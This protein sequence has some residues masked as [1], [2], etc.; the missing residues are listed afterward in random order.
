[1]K[2]LDS[3][4][5]TLSGVKHES[6]DG[7]EMSTNDISLE[8]M[9]TPAPHNKIVSR[10]DKWKNLQNYFRFPPL[11]LFCIFTISLKILLLLSKPC[12]YPSCSLLVLWVCPWYQLTHKEVLD[13]EVTS[14]SID[15]LYLCPS[16]WNFINT[17]YHVVS[18]IEYMSP[19]QI[20]QH[21][22]SKLHGKNITGMLA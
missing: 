3:G 20:N 7:P 5:K 4:I 21:L 11:F 17:F 13:Q 1:M 6:N 8:R 15:I 14:P 12:L 22:A 9:M 18:L 19:L 16:C 2:L 10:E